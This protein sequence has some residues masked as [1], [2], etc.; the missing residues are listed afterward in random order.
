MYTFQFAVP[1]VNGDMYIKHIRFQTLYFHD[2]WYKNLVYLVYQ[3]TDL[4][5][6]YLTSRLCRIRVFQV[7]ALEWNGGIP[8]TDYRGRCLLNRPSSHGRPRADPFPERA[9]QLKRLPRGKRDAAR[10]RDNIVLISHAIMTI[11]LYAR[12]VSLYKVM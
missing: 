4:T 1:R 12:R 11:T 8:A 5:V 2:T 3:S 7:F 9:V 10:H 6:F